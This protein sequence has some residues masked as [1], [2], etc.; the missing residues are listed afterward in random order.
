[1]P[2]APLRSIRVDTPA[3]C[4]APVVRLAARSCAQME[5]FLNAS[6]D[7]AL[8]PAVQNAVHAHVADCSACGQQLRRLRML[9]GLL[10]TLRTATGGR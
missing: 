1:M 8:A 2:K 5:P 9:K 4:G 6:V 10:S 7:A 3:H